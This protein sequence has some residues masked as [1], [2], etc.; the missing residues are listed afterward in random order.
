MVAASCF[1]LNLATITFAQ[2]TT[3]LEGD[4]KL[5]FSR[6]VTGTLTVNYVAPAGCHT[7]ICTTNF[8]PEIHCTITNPQPVVICHTNTYPHLECTTNTIT[9]RYCET[10]IERQLVC[11]TNGT[12][13]VCTTNSISHVHC[14][15]NTYPRLT[16][17][18]NF[19]SYVRCETNISGTR[20][21]TTNMVP[22]I[23]CTNIFPNGISSLRLRETLT[24][25]MTPN[26][27][28]DEL[29]LLIPSN[30]VFQ[31][32]WYSNVRLSDWRGLHSGVFSILLGTNVL[33][34]GTVQGSNGVG[35][36]GALEPCAH[37]SHFEGSLRGY[38]VQE[39]PLRGSLLQATYAGDLPEVNCQSTNIPQGAVNVTIDGVAVTPLC[40]PPT[41]GL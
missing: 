31:S 15:T 30:A 2:D 38:V 40:P 5:G 29:G 39:G 41:P 1:L 27:D 8:V 26:P 20:V 24:G 32:V 25:Q 36:H 7:R 22:R 6:D 3:T 18:T 33:A 23:G 10:N 21:C 16:C 9:Y 14:V 12:E 28:C 35:S 4:T 11:V 37:C 13:L 19:F 34:S 17:T